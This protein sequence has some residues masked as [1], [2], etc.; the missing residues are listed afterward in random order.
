MSLKV[1]AVFAR[2]PSELQSRVRLKI[3]T[4]ALFDGP[5]DFMT[6]KL[7]CFG[8]RLHLVINHYQL[9]WQNTFSPLLHDKQLTTDCIFTVSIFRLLRMFPRACCLPASSFCHATAAWVIS[10]F[11]CF[12]HRFSCFRVTKGLKL[13]TGANLNSDKLNS[14]GTQRQIKSCCSSKGN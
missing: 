2:T 14:K 5:A 6:H 10:H 3:R 9:M 13:S 11:V 8:S 12:Q 4:A 7:I 1:F